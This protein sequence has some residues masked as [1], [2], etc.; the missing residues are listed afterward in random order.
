MNSFVV[1]EPAKYTY[2]GEVKLV[3]KPYQDV[4][5]D[6][7]GHPRTANV[8]ARYYKLYIIEGRVRREQPDIVGNN[9]SKVLSRSYHTG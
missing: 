8:F 6:D 3:D 1:L 2:R 7:N 4:Q 9:H 5:N